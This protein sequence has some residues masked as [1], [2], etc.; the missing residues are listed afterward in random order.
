LCFICCQKSTIVQSVC[1]GWN[2]IAWDDN[3]TCQQTCLWSHRE[4]SLEFYSFF[5]IEVGMT[6]LWEK[7]G[8]LTLCWMLKIQ[9][10]CS[11][12]HSKNDMTLKI[13][14]CSIF[15][16]S[17]L[18]KSQ[19]T[20]LWMHHLISQWLSLKFF[21]LHEWRFPLRY[22]HFILQFQRFKYVSYLNMCRMSTKK[23]VCIIS[24]GLHF[25]VF[26][27]NF[28]HGFFFLY[29]PMSSPK[30]VLINLSTLPLTHLE[31]RL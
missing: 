25:G 15:P 17:M 7:S 20:L 30:Q 24:K 18:L 8:L 22:P 23:L 9:T 5:L 21:I 10:I 6:K 13:V 1:C 3:E 19:T 26:A 2:D 31:K 14:S 29:L 4:H 16:S 28:W 27:T 12:W 11:K